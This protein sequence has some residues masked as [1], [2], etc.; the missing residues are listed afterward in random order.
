MTAHGSRWIIGCAL[1]LAGLV[2]IPSARLA[3]QGFDRSKPPELAPPPELKL[4]PI[5]AGTLPNHLALHVVEM[6][7][8][9]I[10]QFVLLVPAGGRLDGKSPGRASFTADMLD[11]GAG[12]RDA[13]GIASQAAYLGA[14]LETSAD[15]D[16]VYVRLQVPKRNMLEALDLMADVVLR[17]TFAG[18]AVER[19]RS[20]R[21]AGI[22]QQRDDPGVMAALA[23]NALIFPASHP[24]HNSLG[25]DSASTAA[26]DSA[27]VRRFYERYLTPDRA[28]LVVTGDVTLPEVTE[29]IGQ[30]FGEWRTAGPGGGRMGMPPIPASA[31]PPVR[32][33]TLYLVDKPDAAQSVIR[34]GRP[35][36]DRQSPDYYALEV[37]NTIL[38]GSFSSRLNQNLRETKGYSYGAASGFQYRPVAGPF[39]A[40]ASVRTDVT[41]SSLVEFFKEFDQI[42]DQPVSAVELKR[43][44]AYIALGLGGDFETTDQMAGRVA[45]LLTFGLPPTYFN[46]YVRRIMGVTAADVQRVARAYVT[47][48]RFTVVVVGDLA[49]IRPGV[50]ALKLG[51]ISVRDLYGRTL[52]Q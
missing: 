33:T 7:E 9:P 17:P 8:V 10:V 42:R 1:T 19:E 20:L 30:R 35:G 21:L 36:V 15:W 44:K 25:G 28:R 24:Y 34:I 52:S 41:D 43:A 50:E 13:I 12:T 6:H 11:E 49:K 16:Y 29:A 45:E 46:T 22:L 31:I 5:A 40:R 2:L 14:D 26:L 39:L 47:P 27:A 48:D 4:P 38:G 3:A 51:P 32:S 23:S 18:E 37:M